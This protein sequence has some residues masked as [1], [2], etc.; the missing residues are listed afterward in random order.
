MF[1]FHVQNGVTAMHVVCR[2]GRLDLVKV[3]HGRGA[4]IEAASE[5]AKDLFSLLAWSSLFLCDVQK[6]CTPLMSA[7]SG[8]HVDVVDYLVEQNPSLLHTRTQVSVAS[9]RQG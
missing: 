8:G 7:C 6:G 5:V 1:T 9:C 4:S 3:L 2:E